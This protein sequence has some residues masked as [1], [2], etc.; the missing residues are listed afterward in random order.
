M[1]SVAEFVLAQVGPFW[2]VANNGVMF[3]KHPSQASAVAAAVASA[4]RAAIANGPKRVILEEADGRREVIWNSE[5]Q[6]DTRHR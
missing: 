1:Q 5:D 6:P 3:S 2:A 4:T